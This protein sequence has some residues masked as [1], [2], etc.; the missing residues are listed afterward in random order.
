LRFLSESL[1]DRG[2]ELRRGTNNKYGVL[3]RRILQHQTAPRG[4][5]TSHHIA[6]MPVRTA[7]P[8]QHPHPLSMVYHRRPRL[9]FTQTAH[10]RDGGPHGLVA[11]LTATVA[12]CAPREDTAVFSWSGANHGRNGHLAIR[13][14]RATAGPVAWGT[15]HRGLGSQNS[16]RERSEEGRGISPL[17]PVLAASVVLAG[18]T[19]LLALPERGLV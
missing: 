18:Y 10:T 19:H 12:A 13:S 5:C 14:H 2:Q 6:N 11:A 7:Q 8:R 4:T 16:W 1:D 9:H 3:P 17:L 15:G